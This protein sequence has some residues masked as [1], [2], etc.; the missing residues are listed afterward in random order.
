MP[1]LYGPSKGHAPATGSDTRFISSL[2]SFFRSQLEGDCELS[3]FVTERR[4][5]AIEA[6]GLTRLQ[7]S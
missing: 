7:I 2:L 4:K 1:Q 5:G 3:L 6:P